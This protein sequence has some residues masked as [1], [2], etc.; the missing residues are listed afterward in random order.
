MGIWVESLLGRRLPT[1]TA[2]QFHHH[3]PT[4]GLDHLAPG[5]RF[6]Q[7]TVLG[8]FPVLRVPEQ[9]VRDLGQCV[10]RTAAGGRVGDRR[11]PVPCAEDVVHDHTDSMDVLVA[12]LNEAASALMEKF[13]GQQQAVP[14][15]RQVRVNAEFPS[16]PER[17]NLLG[18]GGQVGI[19]A[20]G[21][22]AP[23]DER[24]EVG[25]VAYAVGRVHVDHLDVPAE[26]L[27]LDQAVHDEK[28][29]TRDQPVGPVV[30]VTVELDGLSERRVL[31]RCSEQR[32]LLFGGLRLP[33]RFD[34]RPRINPLVDVE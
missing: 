6:V 1:F 14:Q 7:L 30:P 18:L 4:E 15:V 25:A 10:C 20:V 12:D 17:A 19:L 31:L 22:F 13:A 3:V 5:E 11:Q 24:L 34:D 27:L 8:L 21:H 33:Y 9:V 23:V 29:V 2:R 28:A 32:S 16:I 26:T